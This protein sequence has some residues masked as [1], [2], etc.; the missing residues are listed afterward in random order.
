MNPDIAVV[1]A[2]APEH[3]E[4]FKTI[5]AVAE[6]ELLVSEFSGKVIINKR[7]VDKSYFPL[8]KNQE[9]YNYDRDDLKNLGL[10]EDDLQVAGYHRVDAVA[11]GVA[12]GRDL[13]MSNTSLQ[14]G[15]KSVKPQKGRM[16]I[17]SGKNGSILID[18][19]YNSSPQAV[20]AALDYL[21]SAKNK[22]KIALLGI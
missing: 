2:I 10:R 6:E 9:L 1:T 18:D 11:A 19:T 8:I 14:N 22:Q 21:Y 7:M 5:E 12:V 4:N 13:G 15:A 20:I 17:L 3:M 16:N